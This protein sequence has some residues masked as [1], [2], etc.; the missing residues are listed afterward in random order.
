MTNDH[1]YN[2][3]TVNPQ[4]VSKTFWY[5]L[6][7]EKWPDA[8]SIIQIILDITGIL[9]N[10][11]TATLLIVRLKNGPLISLKLL[12]TAVVCCLL[13]SLVNLMGDVNPAGLFTG[14]YVFNKMIC[15]FWNSRLFYWCFTVIGVQAMVLFCMDRALTIRKLDKLRLTSHDNR[16]LNYQFF[17]YIF[18]FFMVL[19][20]VFTVN[21]ASEKCSCASTMII[22]PFLTLIYA[23]V[24]LWFGLILLLEGGLI[25][26]SA[27]EVIIWVRETPI[28]FQK[29]DL[30]S[31]RDGDAN[32]TT[33][34]RGWR[35][36]SMCLLPI[37]CVYIVTFGYDASYQFMSAIS[38]IDYV[39]NSYQQR[40]GAMLLVVYSNAIPVILLTYVASLR[41]HVRSM[42]LRMV[43][44]LGV[45]KRPWADDDN[46]P[47]D[48]RI[49]HTLKA[50]VQISVT[51]HE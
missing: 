12:R 9:L 51:E 4:I 42:F 24:Y 26:A 49:E 21:I 23:H 45:S 33:T 2:F 32:P 10:G 11:F 1:N 20:Q 25:V 29:D 17:I 14:N 16:F 28:K 39:I 15:I 48:P 7:L 43:A 22:I 36:S 41:G 27:I 37:A 47:E 38:S 44:F 19:P 30:N 8:F 35:T 5:C 34:H 13:S 46:A 31:L 18:S 3:S 6:R 50:D 40:F